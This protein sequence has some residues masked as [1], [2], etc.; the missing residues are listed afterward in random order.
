MANKRKIIDTTWSSGLAYVVG[1][2]AA[3]GNLSPDARHI[4]FTSKDKILAET[5]KRILKLDNKISMKARGG[6]TVKKYYVT[7]FG[8][9]DFYKFLLSVGLTPAK[10]KTLQR[11][12]IP[13]EYFQHFLRGCIDGDG[14][15]CEFKHPQS[16]QG[17]LRVRLASASQVFLAWIH[18]EIRKHVQVS[19]G[20]IY[21]DKRKSVMSLTFAKSDSIR[22]LSYIYAESRN[23]F[24]PRKQKTV[25]KYLAVK[26]AGMAKL[27]RRAS[28]RN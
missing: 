7:Q 25:T 3:D 9:V 13:T 22:I 14:N 4:S 24:L 10:S 2:I 11:L 27:V 18:E 5:V 26:D 1:L 23:D 20:W 15:I 17:Q 19:G 21:H 28:L 12:E 6:E 8:S 16:R